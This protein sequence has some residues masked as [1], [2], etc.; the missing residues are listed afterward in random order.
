MITLEMIK[1]N[2]VKSL[3]DSTPEI[4]DKLTD[5]EVV[6]KIDSTVSKIMDELISLLTHIEESGNF[7]ELEEELCEKFNI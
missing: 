7:I 2:V 6:I 1:T 3:V 4:K 5:P